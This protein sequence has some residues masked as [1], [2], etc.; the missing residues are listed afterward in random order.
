M[1]RHRVATLTAGLLVLAACVHVHEPAP[2]AARRGPPAHAAAH[3]YRAQRANVELRYD[4]HLGVY[5]VLGRPDHFFDGEQFYRRVASHWERCTSFE[6][7][8][9]RKVAASAVPVRLA[10]HYAPRR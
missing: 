3:G 4:A 8:D 5:V 9:W 7:G 2:V 10:Q 1:P 6:D